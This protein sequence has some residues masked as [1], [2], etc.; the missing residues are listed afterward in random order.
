ML[1]LSASAAVYEA[2]HPTALLLADISGR[3]ARAL[4]GRVPPAKLI[5]RTA[6]SLVHGLAWLLL[7]QEVRLE[8]A[9]R[10]E[11]LIDQV[12]AILTAGICTLGGRP[13]ASSMTT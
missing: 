9:E 13:R 4:G 3:C 2:A 6:W 5:E 1:A 10:V 12:L 8:P 7:E 11:A